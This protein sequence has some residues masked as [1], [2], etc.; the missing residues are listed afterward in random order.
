MFY[1]QEKRR[2]TQDDAYVEQTFLEDFLSQQCFIYFSCMDIGQ[3][4][5]LVS[6]WT[7]KVEDSG[8]YLD[9]NL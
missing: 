1:L 7:V 4:V 9:Q 8:K 3:H 5:G 2:K 6:N